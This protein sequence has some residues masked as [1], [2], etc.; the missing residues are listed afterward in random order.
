M[1]KTSF[2]FD[3]MVYNSVVNGKVIY[4][5]DVTKT[6]DF[7]KI[8][9]DTRQIQI[10]TTDGD[11]FLANQDSEFYFEVDIVKLKGQPN[12]SKIKGNGK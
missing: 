5:D 11:I 4:Y 10:H 8:I 6:I 12:M 7:V 1:A 3:E 9:K 2:T